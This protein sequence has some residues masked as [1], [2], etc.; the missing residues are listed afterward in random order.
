MKCELNQAWSNERV[1]KGFSN[2]EKEVVD[3]NMFLADLLN[4]IKLEWGV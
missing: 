4:V 1:R 3:N 2:S